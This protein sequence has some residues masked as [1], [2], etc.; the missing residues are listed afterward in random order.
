MISVLLKIGQIE[1]YKS[2]NYQNSVIDV[3]TVNSYAGMDFE[4][5]RNKQWRKTKYIF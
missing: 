3:F 4:S 5:N 1:K 2:L